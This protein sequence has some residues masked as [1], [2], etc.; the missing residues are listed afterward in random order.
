MT[1]EEVIEEYASGAFTQGEALDKLAE[2]AAV[3]GVGAILG[4]LPLMW[5]KDLELHIFHM[6]DNETDSDD[7]IDFGDPEPDL[8]LRRK[9]ITVLR[10]WIAKKK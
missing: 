4:K 9:N 2:L 1:W 6:Y 7:Y 3:N 10:D 5:R 8:A